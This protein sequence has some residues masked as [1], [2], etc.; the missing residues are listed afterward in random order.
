MTEFD[1][2]EDAISELDAQIRYHNEKFK[3]SKEAL[4]P[5]SMFHQE[6]LRVFGFLK[7]LATTYTGVGGTLLG[8]EKKNKCYIP[9]LDMDLSHFVDLA[10]D[11]FADARHDYKDELPENPTDNQFLWHRAQLAAIYDCERILR[12]YLHWWLRNAGTTDES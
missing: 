5:A 10:T 9:D 2:K 7:R 4:G 8:K 6:K 3:K 11:R 1:L 12:D